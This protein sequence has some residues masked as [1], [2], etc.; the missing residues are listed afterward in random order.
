MLRAYVTLEVLIRSASRKARAQARQRREL[1]DLN[2]LLRDDLRAIHPTV[3]DERIDAA[4]EVATRNFTADIGSEGDG[5]GAHDL[6]IALKAAAEIREVLTTH[7]HAY[8]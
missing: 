7:R 8:S 6:G 3:S 1:H 2:T 4:V 5:F